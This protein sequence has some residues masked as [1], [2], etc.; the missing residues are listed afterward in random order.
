MY[1]LIQLFSNYN[2]SFEIMKPAFENTPVGCPL[3]TLMAEEI[4]YGILGHSH[5]RKP[6]ELDHFDGVIGFISDLMQII[7]KRRHEVIGERAED[8]E[9]MKAYIVGRGPKKYAFE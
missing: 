7:L 6:E 4:A 1:L 3:R 9:L 5:V 8:I 2:P